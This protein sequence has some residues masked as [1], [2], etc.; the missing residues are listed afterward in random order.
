MSA[1]PRTCGPAP[2]GSRLTGVSARCP[3]AGDNYQTQLIPVQD[4]EGLPF[5][6]H[7]QRF[8]IFTFSFVDPGARQAFQGLVRCLCP[9]SS[10]GLR[11]PAPLFP[12]QVTLGGGWSLML[13]I[14]T[15]SGQPQ[16]TGDVSDV[17]G[18]HPGSPVPL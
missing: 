11:P 14:G 3:Y 9:G 18:R 7:Y 1:P 6:S 17:C 10:A 2:R 12:C 5:P 16:Y 4:A 15:A 13:A 8:S